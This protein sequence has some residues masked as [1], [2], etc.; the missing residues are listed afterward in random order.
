MKKS[1]LTEILEILEKHQ[2]WLDNVEGGVKADLSYA[3]LSCA[4]LIGTDLSYANLR[5]ANLRNANLSYAN[6]RNAN[7]DYSAWPL[8]CGT[9]HS[10]IKVCDKLKAQL[11]YHA[12][13]VSS[14]TEIKPTSEQLAFIEKN[15]HRYEEVEKLSSG[16][17]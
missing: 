6:L 9:S 11:L 15:F 5:G 7:L 8:C 4:D 13:I 16:L 2:L 12:F 14:P 10:S 1:E 17:R 3:D